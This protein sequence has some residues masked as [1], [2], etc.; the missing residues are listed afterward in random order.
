MIPCGNYLFTEP[1]SEYSASNR[2][3]APRPSW[4]C[5]RRSSTPLPLLPSFLG[6][7]GMTLVSSMMLRLPTNADELLHQEPGENVV[8][9]LRQT[10]R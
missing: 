3:R 1:T 2:L 5:R 4:P 7:A 6:S 8:P 9:L 10:Q